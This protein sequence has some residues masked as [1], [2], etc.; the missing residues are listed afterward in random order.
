VLDKLVSKKFATS[1]SRA[2][3]FVRNWKWTSKDQNFVANLIAGKKMKPE[4]AAEQWVKAN[5]SKVN[6][7]LK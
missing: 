5:A 2:V 1:G 7:W 4:K 6:A 3:R